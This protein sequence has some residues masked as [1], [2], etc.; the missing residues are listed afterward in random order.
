MNSPELSAAKRT[1]NKD[2]IDFFNNLKEASSKKPYLNGE[3]LFAQVYKLDAEEAHK[4]LVK[5]L[6]PLQK[7]IDHISPQKEKKNNNNSDINLVE[8]CYCCNHNLKKGFSFAEFHSIY[9]SIKINMPEDKFQYALSQILDSPQSEIFRRLSAADMI[10]Y[11]K[12]LFAQ[13]TETQNVLNSINYRIQGCKTGIKDSIEE[14]K[15]EI[16]EKE[17]EKKDLE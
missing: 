9:P 6:H 12:G 1:E 16:A 4:R 11:V 10:K 8:A 17:K 15:K 2:E 5:N 14:C 13:R 3:G 7:T